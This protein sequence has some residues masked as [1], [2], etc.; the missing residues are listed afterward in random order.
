MPS[1]RKTLPDRSS[2]E[3]LPDPRSQPRCNREMD[4]ETAPRRWTSRTA[5]RNLSD[6]QARCARDSCPDL[7]EKDDHAFSGP[8]DM[9][10]F[11]Q[12][13]WPK[14]L[15]SLKTPAGGGSA[16]PRALVN[17]G[18]LAL[19]REPADSGEE[20][21]R[22]HSPVIRTAASVFHGVGHHRRTCRQYVS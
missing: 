17:G 21:P 8:L 20:F 16:A 12:P 22:S 3:L 15:S 6:Q 19:A 11:I 9:Q 10:V 5:G 14:I 2:H 18:L 4:P 7:P 13:G 1:R